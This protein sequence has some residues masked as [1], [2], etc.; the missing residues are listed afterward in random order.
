M[1]VHPACFATMADLLFRPCEFF[2]CVCVCVG[3][4]FFFGVFCGVAETVTGANRMF[5][6]QGNPL[7]APAIGISFAKQVF[8]VYRFCR[9]RL[10]LIEIKPRL[11]SFRTFF[12]VLF[13]RYKSIHFVVL[14]DPPPLSFELCFVA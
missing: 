3:L 10:I 12:F 6:G 9:R 5:K 1:R 13:F 11:F 7:Y 8:P 14:Y 4:G 2:V